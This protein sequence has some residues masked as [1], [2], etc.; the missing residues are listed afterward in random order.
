[1]T[2]WAQLSHR[3]VPG[4]DGSRQPWPDCLQG[5][6]PLRRGRDSRALGSPLGQRFPIGTTRAHTFCPRGR[7][8]SA[9]DEGALTELPICPRG[10]CS[11]SCG[12]QASSPPRGH[13]RTRATRSPPRSARRPSAGST[14]SSPPGAIPRSVRSSRS[15]PSSRRR[16]AKAGTPGP[17]RANMSPP[18]STTA[19]GAIGPRARRPRGHGNFTMREGSAS[20]S[21]SGSKPRFAATSQSSPWPSARSSRSARGSARTGRAGSR[22][23]QTRW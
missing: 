21:A 2:G 8:N 10:P 6:A 1:M 18:C 3:R 7:Y 14:S 19:W 9:R 22:R 13:W 20:C 16:A 11:E 17:A 15:T 23:A 12:E 4:R 5:R